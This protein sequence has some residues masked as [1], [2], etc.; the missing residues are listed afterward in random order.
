MEQR[1]GIEGYPGGNWHK[2]MNPL[3]YQD[4]DVMG[5]SQH[6]R[7]HGDLSPWQRRRNS[8]FPPLLFFRCLHLPF[9][10]AYLGVEMQRA[11]HRAGRGGV[12]EHLLGRVPE[13]VGAGQPQKCH[14]GDLAGPRAQRPGEKGRR[15]RAR[16]ESRTSPLPLGASGLLTCGSVGTRLASES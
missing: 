7:G 14:P 11:G 13:E 6:G 12:L 1:E 2:L 9:A 16:C 10:E 8:T 3:T 15:S 5:G 4:G